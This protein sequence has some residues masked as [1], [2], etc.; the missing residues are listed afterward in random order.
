MDFVATRESIMSQNQI[1][2]WNYIDEYPTEE[3]W[4]PVLQ[5]FEIEEG[6]IPRAAYFTGKKWSI[7]WIV[8]YI[9][10][11]VSSAEEAEEIAYDNDQDL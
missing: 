5:C 2:N 8:A 3:G 4:Y 10:T 6:F 11:K 9:N 7:R 1:I